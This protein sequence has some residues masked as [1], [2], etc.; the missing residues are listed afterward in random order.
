[1]ID[2]EVTRLS[3]LVALLTLLQTK[4]MRTAG[5]LAQHFSVS[6]RT[7]YRDIRT[8]ESAGIPVVTIEGKGYA[9]LEGYRLPPVMFS[10]PEAIALLTAEKLA[11]RL[12]DA[13]TAALTGTAMDKVRAALRRSDRDHLETLAPHIEV[14]EPVL[15]PAYSNAYQELVSAVTNR[16]VVRLAY[17]GA[18][19]QLPTERAVEPIGLYLS[20]Q[21]HMIGF[22]RLR[23]SFRDFRLDRIRKLLVTDEAFAERSETLQQYWAEEATRRQKQ[24][25]V[26]R[27]DPSVVAPAMAQQLYDTRHRYGWTHETIRADGSREMVF[28]IG[29][30]PYLAAWLLPYANALTIPDSTDLL[31]LLKDMARAINSALNGD[32]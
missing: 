31:H 22:C 23:Q 32:V 26:I 28:L 5:E 3:R 1:M 7:I 15:P 8:L 27:F 14:M 25:V 20:Q 13:P 17:A 16:R 18:E 9:M 30:L 4:R 6:T 2:P 10:Q 21:W 12:T 24:M 29:S 11:S 19:S